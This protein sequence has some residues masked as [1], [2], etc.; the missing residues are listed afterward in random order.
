MH[1]HVNVKIVHGSVWFGIDEYTH[2]EAC[3]FQYFYHELPFCGWQFL[4]IT[5]LVYILYQILMC[6]FNVCIRSCVYEVVHCKLGKK[7][8]I[9]KQQKW[10]AVI[11][12]FCMGGSWFELW[13]YYCLQNYFVNSVTK[14]IVTPWNG[15]VT[16]V[17]ILSD[18]S[19]KNLVEYWGNC[20]CLQHIVSFQSIQGCW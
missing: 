1:G 3:L 10:L 15:K 11:L 17:Q 14:F 19:T 4:F 13:L 5:S 8:A 12:D 2:T 9:A 18:I 20:L 7:A 6:D 16:I